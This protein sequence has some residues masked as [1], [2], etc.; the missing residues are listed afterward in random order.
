MR[1]D[2]R[3]ALAKV[4]QT[5]HGRMRTREEAVQQA[6]DRQKKYQTQLLSWMK[7][8]VNNSR[9]R[10]GKTP[11]DAQLSEMLSLAEE[12]A[13]VQNP[14]DTIERFY[15]KHREAT[16]RDVPKSEERGIEGNSTAIFSESRRL[17][18]IMAGSLNEFGKTKTSVLQASEALDAK[19]QNPYWSTE[20]ELFAR[21]FESWL[22]DKITGGKKRS[23]YLVA[24]VSE[25]EAKSVWQGAYPVGDER[26]AIGQA[27]SELVDAL[28]VQLVGPSGE[29]E[30][31][32]K[33]GSFGGSTGARKADVDA[34]GR[35]ARYRAGMAINP[36]EEVADMLRRARAQ[37]R[38]SAAAPARDVAKIEAR[39]ARQAERRLARSERAAA[40]LSAKLGDA[41]ESKKAYRDVLRESR[42]DLN[43][44]RNDIVSLGEKLRDTNTRA[45]AQKQAREVVVKVAQS[46]PV[47]LRGGLLTDVRDAKTV[48]DV[49]RAVTKAQDAVAKDIGR[50]AKSV[51]D[52]TTARKVTARL[53][54][55]ARDKLAD[56][57]LKADDALRRFNA[58]LASAGDAAIELADLADQAKAVVHEYRLENKL[59]RLGQFLDADAARAAAAAADPALPFGGV[60]MGIKE[61]DAVGLLAN[62]VG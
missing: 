31:T 48:A 17:D 28:E 39:A 33:T 60:P 16:G 36:I 51:L 53:G 21:T 58:P 25:S 19:R 8:T 57:R 10:G 50:N 23:D 59:I 1:A 35:G 13:K 9:V 44:A 34:R 46:L 5:I 27:F 3:D 24:G 26:T 14:T 22:Y 41:T 62:R 37:G 29:Q 7:A 15:A 43:R 20:H 47:R 38:K 6:Q 12:A 40:N 52:R 30:S 4:M 42:R 55:D 2:L 61:Q 49:Y 54:D 11:T 45:D 56:I 32:F 18:Q